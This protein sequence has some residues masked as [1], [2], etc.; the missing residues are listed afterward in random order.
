MICNIIVTKEDNK[1]TA[2]VKEWPNVIVEENTCDE[3]V[4]QAKTQLTQYMSHLVEITQ[5][6]V[7]CPSKTGNPWLDNFGF[8]RDD[9]TFED[10]QDEI[11]AYR[12]EII[13][14]GR[15]P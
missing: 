1:Y 9:P 7:P 4:S 5:I 11:A 15:K 14:H 8:C 13:E 12:Q 2:R 10:L 6:D 3:A